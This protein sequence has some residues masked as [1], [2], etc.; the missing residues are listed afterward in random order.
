MKFSK[1]A[2][3]TDLGSWFTLAKDPVTGAISEVRIRRLPAH[4]AR[5]LRRNKVK[6]KG[7]THVLDL[8]QEEI[9]AREE[10]KE[11]WTGARGLT[12][13]AKDEK[14]AAVYASLCPGVVFPVGAEV[15]IDECLTDALKVDLLTDYPELLAFIRKRA[16]GLQILDDEEEEEAQGN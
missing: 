6:V 9:R 12:V 5:R 16:K 13:V 1:E 4:I 15:S 2:V 8:G 10:V 14:S 3:P 7:D 11:C